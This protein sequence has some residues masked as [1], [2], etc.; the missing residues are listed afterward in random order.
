[1]ENNTTSLSEGILIG[2]FIDIQREGGMC[3]NIEVNLKKGNIAVV[4]K[5]Q[6]FLLDDIKKVVF[7]K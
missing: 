7:G 2:K 6:S 5:K 3:G 4:N 1:M